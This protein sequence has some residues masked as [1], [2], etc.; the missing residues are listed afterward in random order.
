MNPCCDECYYN[1]VIIEFVQC[2]SN[3]R[4]LFKFI[5]IF[6]FHHELV[7]FFDLQK[8]HNIYINEFE[9]IK[10]DG[11]N[12]DNIRYADDTVLISTSQR[13]LHKMLNELGKIR[14]LYGISINVNKTEYLVVT[15]LET[16]PR[17]PLSFKGNS[18]KQTEHFR[19]LGL[20]ISS[21]GRCTNEIK[22]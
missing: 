6:D 9:G 15:K 12:I 20:L 14:E 10:V 13:P 8:L 4:G 1:F 11:V 5:L 3:L 17:L 19:Y 21:N 18:I 7:A 2:C 22:R 16:V